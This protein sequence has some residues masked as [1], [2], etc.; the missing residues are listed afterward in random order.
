MDAGSALG[1]EFADRRVVCVGLQEFHEGFAGGETDNGRAVGVAEGNLRHLQHISHDRQQLVDG[2][3]G[4]PDVG[5]AR[6]AANG[7][8]HGGLVEGVG[9][10]IR[11]LIPHSRRVAGQPRPRLNGA[12]DGQRS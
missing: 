1:D 12:D 8:S 4:N 6:A 11:I 5:D 3:N 9:D 7:L 2:A 10:N